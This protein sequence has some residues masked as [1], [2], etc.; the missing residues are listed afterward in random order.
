MSE[1]VN[2]VRDAFDVAVNEGGDEDSVKMAMIQAGAT[3]KSVANSYN[4]FMIDAGLTISKKDRNVILDDLLPG[5]NISIEDDFFSVV[6]TVVTS[7]P[8]CNHRGAMA[9]IRHWAKK[10][11]V[12]VYR[13][14]VGDGNVRN[15]FVKNFHAALIKNPQM[16]KEGLDEVIGALNDEQRVN[17]QRCFTHYNAIRKMVNAV[18][19]KHAA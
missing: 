1:E 17:P 9:M 3:F 11:G 16:S 5:A 6:A 8:G 12:D 14:I 2:K 4:L 18:Y 7:I 10:N 15:P 13:N 19:E